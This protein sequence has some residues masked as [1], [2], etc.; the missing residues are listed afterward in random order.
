MESWKSE[1]W[2]CFWSFEKQIW[3]FE[4]FKRGSPICSKRNHSLLYTSQFLIDN[5]ERGNEQIMDMHPN[6]LDEEKQDVDEYEKN[7]KLESIAKT[8]RNRLY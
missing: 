1:D 3:N 2:E 4:E 8:Y 6:S 5:E 7:I